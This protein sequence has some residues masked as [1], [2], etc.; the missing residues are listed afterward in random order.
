MQKKVNKTKNG[1]F[2]ILNYSLKYEIIYSALFLAAILF[3][4]PAFAPIAIFL[5]AILLFQNYRK[6]YV[7]MGLIVIGL[8][9]LAI[10]IMLRLDIYAG[11]LISYNN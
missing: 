4:V 1:A 9:I 2:P 11:T 10:A 5:S 7:I 6:R 8:N 3:S